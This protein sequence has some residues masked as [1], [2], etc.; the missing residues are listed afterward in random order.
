MTPLLLH[1]VILLEFPL[2]LKVVCIFLKSFVDQSSEMQSSMIVRTRIV[3]YVNAVVKM[4]KPSRGH[5]KN[6]MMRL[7]LTRR[8]KPYAYIV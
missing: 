7:I 3:N 6:C 1:C 5:S 8:F 2:Q 4:V